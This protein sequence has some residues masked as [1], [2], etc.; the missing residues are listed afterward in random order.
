MLSSCEKN[1]RRLHIEKRVYRN[2]YYVHVPWERRTPVNAYPKPEPYPVDHSRTAHTDS[3][4]KNAGGVPANSSQTT[5]A[6]GAPPNNSPTGNGN[7]G[8]GG[9]NGGGSNANAGGGAVGPGNG[10]NGTNGTYAGGAQP[11]PPLQY[12]PDYGS[13]PLQRPQTSPPVSTQAPPPP[14]SSVTV[15]ESVTPDE[16]KKDRDIHFPEGELSLIAEFGFC[17]PV[18][19]EGIEIKPGS[20]NGGVAMRYS[21]HPWSRHK[22]SGEG[23][24][25]LS[26]HFIQQDHHRFYPMFVEAHDHERVMQ[27]KTRFMLMDHIYINRNPEAKVDAI[28]LGVFS[29]IGFFSTHVAVNNTVR[30]KDAAFSRDKSRLFGLHYLRHT[31]FG[32]TARIANE[33]WSV[34]ANFRFTQLVKGSPDGGDLPRLVVGATFA[35]GE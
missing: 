14:D 5:N 7:S 29:D 24:L 28:E 11:A 35:F 31:Q 27:I 16:P 17:N 18:Y 32:M 6:N 23:G 34:F 2:G 26:Q 25:F 30:T 20:Y 22:I 13:P 10:P 19:T 9:G 4:Q 8:N 33:V 15:N 3:T 1:W 21:I 12:E